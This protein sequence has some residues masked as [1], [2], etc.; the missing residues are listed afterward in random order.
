MTIM[1]TVLMGDRSDIWCE[2]TEK[3]VKIRTFSDAFAH[4]RIPRMTPLIVI[5]ILITRNIALLL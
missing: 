4:P 5:I 3:N 1:I 2:E